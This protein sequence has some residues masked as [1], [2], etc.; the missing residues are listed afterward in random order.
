MFETL[1]Y[2]KMQNNKYHIQL[3]SQKINGHKACIKRAWLDSPKIRK[4]LQ[5]S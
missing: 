2:Y 1:T 5:R 3:I 4:H